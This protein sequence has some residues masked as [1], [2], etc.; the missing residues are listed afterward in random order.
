MFVT[1]VA[2]L[3]F[4][5][6]QMYI[7]H[8]GDGHYH[9][10]GGYDH[11]EH[12]EED[13]DHNHLHNLEHKHEHKHDKKHEH[14]SKV[15]AYGGAQDLENLDLKENLLQEYKADEEEHK[16]EHKEH[17]HKHSDH[18]S[19][20]HKHD[21]F[22]D[23]QHDQSHGTKIAGFN[24]NV[25]AAFLHVLGDMLMSVGVIIAAIMVYIK[26]AWTI[27]DPLCTYL[28]SIIVCCTTIPVFKDCI[29]V[30]MEGTPENIDVE[31]LMEDI[32]KIKGV[33]EIHDFHV[34][35]ISVGKFALS[36]HIMSD[37]PLK[38]LS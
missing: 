19:H 7:L 15:Q 14:K 3:F 34:W 12:G 29:R 1:A 6:C 16:Y 11:H 2:G 24:I 18:G 36:A 37:S 35:S 13:H 26:P 30:M 5:L 33:E 28:F 4:N 8:S 20:S 38:T 17:K 23:H 21:H 27:A 31:E 10:G 22:H 9:L 32:F 25:Q